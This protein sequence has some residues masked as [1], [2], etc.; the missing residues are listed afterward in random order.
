MT[1]GETP[2]RSREVENVVKLGLYGSGRAG[3]RDVKRSQ[4]EATSSCS[5][6]GKECKTTTKAA[7]WPEISS[8]DMEMNIKTWK[9]RKSY[10]CKTTTKKK[11]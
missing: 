3:A 9:S 2:C 10:E 8:K 5:E 6:E 1:Q 7:K 4:E 11:H